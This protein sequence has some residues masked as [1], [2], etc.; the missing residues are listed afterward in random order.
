MVA[1]KVFEEE[2]IDLKLEVAKMCRMA[3]GM[4]DDSIDALMRQDKELAKNVTLRDKEVDDFEMDIEKKCMRLLLKEQPVAKDFRD[5]STT[6]KIITDIERIGDQASDISEIVV[7]FPSECYFK[8]L[9]LIKKMGVLAIEMVQKS[10]T[11]FIQE[12]EKLADEVIALD[13]VMDDLFEQIKSELIDYIRKD[14]SIADQAI[15]FMMI[16]K[17]LERIGDHTVNVC[18]WTKYNETGVHIKY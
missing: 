10:I 7:S 14:S 5:V 9:V 11:S 13:D 2:L 6:L 12:D 1:R 16:S 18:E 15:M 8:E 17:Y 3:E 4:I